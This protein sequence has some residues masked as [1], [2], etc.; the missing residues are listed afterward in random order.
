VGSDRPPRGNADSS[1]SEDE[2][3]TASLGGDELDL[4]LKESAT[5]E[6]GDLDTN[7]MASTEMDRLLAEVKTH[8]KSD[9]PIGRGRSS[10]QPPP[11]P[12]GPFARSPSAPPESTKQ[13]RPAPPPEAAKATREVE[14]IEIPAEARRS[15]LPPS[16]EAEAAYREIMRPIG[17]SP[18]PKVGLHGLRATEP[19]PSPPPVASTM[20][21][22]TE[23]EVRAAEAAMRQGGARR[24]W[25]GALIACAIAFAGVVFVVRLMAY[26]P[27]AEEDTATATTALAPATAPGTAT[28]P[29]AATAIAAAPV[30]VSRARVDARAALEHFSDGL[31]DCVRKSIG[32]LP[33]SSPAMPVSPAMLK[34]AGYTP[35]FPE[36]R[37]PVF[38]CAK[39][40]VDAPIRFSLQ[41][42]SIKAGV[43]GQAVAWI[44]DD[45]DGTIDAALA[46]HATLKS[47]GVVESTA[48][49]PIDKA[50]PAVA[51][52]SG[53]RERPAAPSADS[54]Y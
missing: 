27:H 20:A 15:D 53:G 35:T 25:I 42:Q 54:V 39:L 3:E 5:K 1:A 51:V 36:L 37:S 46:F 26:D 29:A 21:P 16:P 40:K 19:M 32:V 11:S 24:R 50:T 41:W 33:G 13:T 49:E 2:K 7:T 52:A 17:K 48:V 28:S 4:L 34:G 22:E 47:H 45:G 6:L 31:R 10:S 43:E 44:D 8:Q 9:R 12:L 14:R 38:I 23:A 18:P 30:T